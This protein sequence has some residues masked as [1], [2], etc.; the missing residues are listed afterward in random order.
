MSAAM[1]NKILII[2]DDYYLSKNMKLLLEQDSFKVL[3]ASGCEMAKAVFDRE[4]PDLCLVD[5]MLPDGNGFELCEYIR[6]RSQLPV[7]I[8][9]A[10]DEEDSIVKGL[11][12][13]A[14]DYVTKPFKP[15]ELL[16]RIRANLRRVN[17]PEKRKILSCEEIELQVEKHTVTKNGVPMELRNMEY[18]LLYSFLKHPEMVL[19]RETLLEQLWDKDGSFVED[20]TLSVTMKRLREKLG[21]TM[22]GESYIT[23]IR[24]IG[25][26]W[27]YP[28]I[29]K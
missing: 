20:N 27:N 18:Q 16:S 28:V 21:E 8:I 26:R 17:M 25:Y 9:S 1:E 19:T 6:Q 23:T 5:I 10:K 7:L 29:C 4:Q 13:G 15:K 11:E 12:L 24:G 14:D 22:D 3:T 2:E